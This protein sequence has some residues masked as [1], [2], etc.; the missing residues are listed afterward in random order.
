MS[1]SRFDRPA[2]PFASG[3]QMPSEAGPVGCIR[4]L[5]FYGS[6]R[7]HTGVG[8][9]TG[10]G[11]NRSSRAGCKVR[12]GTNDA[13]AIVHLTGPARRS[14]AYAFILVGRIILGRRSS[15]LYLV[16][17]FV[18]AARHFVGKVRCHV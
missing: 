13:Q 2:A 6:C 16:T 4:R 5:V 3:Y 15:I 1:A 10:G 14:R 8:D 12:C 7:I 9:R 11:S 17:K 18:C